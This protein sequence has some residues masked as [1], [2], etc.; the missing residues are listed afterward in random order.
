M[1]DSKQREL[2]I[3]VQN[4]PPQVRIGIRDLGTGIAPEVL[5]RLFEPFLTTK[6]PG[7]GLGLGL[8][9]SYSMVQEFGGRLTA[10]NH[11]EGGAEFMI[12][13]FG[14]TAQQAGAL[15]DG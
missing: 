4:F 8:A 3:S 11:P 7:K 2:R 14:T 1:A 12:E 5:S 15:L 10:R 9:I 13:L 6:P